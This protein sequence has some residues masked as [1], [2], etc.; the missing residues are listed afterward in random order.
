MPRDMIVSEGNRYL[1]GVPR[2]H[3]PGCDTQTKLFAYLCDKH[4]NMLPID[5]RWFLTKTYS[6]H[7]PR[8]IPTNHK[9]K[10]KY[11][12]PVLEFYM[13]Y[14]AE[15]PNAKFKPILGFSKKPRAEKWAILEKRKAKYEQTQRQ[16]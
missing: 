8:L 7:G 15:H 16:R 4:R 11:F 6:V 12:L 10:F 2:C 3:W 14:L 1:G 13:D 5:L 9:S